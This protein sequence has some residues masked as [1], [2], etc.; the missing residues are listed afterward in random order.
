M[1]SL[2]SNNDNYFNDIIAS[3][4]EEIKIHIDIINPD[5][6]YSDLFYLSNVKIIL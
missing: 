2:I 4:R 5:C 1:I 3:M 6:I